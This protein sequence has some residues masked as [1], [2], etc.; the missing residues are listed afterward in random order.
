MKRYKR[1]VDVKERDHRYHF[2]THDKVASARASVREY[3]IIGEGVR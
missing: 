3:L 1:T 2:G